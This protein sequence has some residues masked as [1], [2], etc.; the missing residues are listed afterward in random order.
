M[1][2]TLGDDM[3]NVAILLFYILFYCL[4]YFYNN[5]LSMLLKCDKV[6]ILLVYI[7]LRLLVA[8]LLVFIC[9]GCYKDEHSNRTVIKRS[10]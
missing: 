7:N 6:I 10:S 2:K 8:F 3:Y 4:S 5:E 9:F 1:E